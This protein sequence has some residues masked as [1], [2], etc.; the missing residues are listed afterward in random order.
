MVFLQGKRIF[1]SNP[2]KLTS[3]KHTWKSSQTLESVYHPIGLQKM[4]C[5]HAALAIHLKQSKCVLSTML[6]NQ[7]ISIFELF[8]FNKMLG[9][10]S[11]LQ[12]AV[13]RDEDKYIRML[14][15]YV[16]FKDKLY[17]DKFVKQT[18]LFLSSVTRQG[19]LRLVTSVSEVSGLQINGSF[20]CEQ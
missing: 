1:T 13:A 7:L 16:M 12:K 11:L 6:K 18:K 19:R 10:T 3:L 20:K 9:N 15:S 8:I 5:V 4:C 2:E 17:S 14:S